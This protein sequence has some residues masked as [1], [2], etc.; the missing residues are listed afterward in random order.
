ML[1]EVHQALD[2]GID[3][4]TDLVYNDY[5]NVAR[6]TGPANAKGQ[7]YQLE[8]TYDSVVQGFVERIE[9]HPF[10]Y[11]STATYDYALGKLRSTTDRNQNTLR[12]I[13]DS[14]GRMHSI[15]GPYQQGGTQATLRFDYHPDAQPPYA[16]TRHY[17]PYRDPSGADTLDTVLFTDG[18]KRVLQTKQ[19]HALHRS[20][21]QPPQ[22]GMSVSGRVQFDALGRSIAQYYPRFEAAGLAG[23][24]NATFDRITPTLT[25]YDALHTLRGQ[26]LHLTSRSC[27]IMLCP[28]HSLN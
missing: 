14:V 21:G 5:G 10:G 20:P 4:R 24:F 18:L 9:D 26:A 12:Y 8:F 23:V 2:G 11:V 6:V 22:V 7:R 1:I 15:T 17:D 25:D 28:T 27:R 13:Y 19:D 16:I 3:V